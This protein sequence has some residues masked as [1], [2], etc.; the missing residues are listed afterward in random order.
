MQ[1]GAFTGYMDVAQVVLYAFWIFFAGLIFYLRREDKREGYPL[2][3]DRTVASGGQILVQGWPAPPPPKTYLLHD[4]KTVTVPSSA[5][6][7]VDT[8]LKP[9]AHL[10]AP[11]EPVGDAMRDGVGPAAW[12][13][14]ADTPDLTWA[15]ENRVVPMR[16]AED[17]WVEENDPDPRGWNVVAGDGQIAGKVTELWIDLAE[18]LVR[19][20]EVALGKG[21]RNVLVPYVFANVNAATKELEVDAL[22]AAQFAGVPSI[23][24]PNQITA[25]EEDKICGYFGGGRTYSV[26][27]RVEPLL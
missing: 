19:Y 17:H 5:P 18:P 15:G 10:G 24:S 26:A 9:G 13:Q 22:T 25:L 27:T 11:F 16:V 8:R 21:G 4:G 2:D 20:Y 23:K 12:A 7:P 3:S 14:R 1:T 6:V